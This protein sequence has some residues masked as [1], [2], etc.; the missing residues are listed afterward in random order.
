[1]HSVG[2]RAVGVTKSLS[3]NSRLNTRRTDTSRIISYNDNDSLIS[4]GGAGDSNSRP[5]SKGNPS[6]LISGRES[7]SKE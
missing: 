5:T 7:F 3:K 1:V 4:G 2:S 6:Q